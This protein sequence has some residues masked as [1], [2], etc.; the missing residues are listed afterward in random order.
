MRTALAALCCL[1]LSGIAAAV[2][3]SDQVTSQAN[4]CYGEVGEHKL[5]LDVFLPSDEATSGS[6]KRLGVLLIHGGGWVG[7]NK[8]AYWTDAKWF[9]QHGIVAFCVGY[10][11]VKPDTNRWPTQLDDIQLAVR[12]VRAHAAEYN[13]DPDQV[14]ATGGSAGGH[15]VS[16]LGTR[17]TRKGTTAPLQQYSSK[18]QAVVDVF[19]PADLTK[20][21]P[22]TGPYNLNVQKMVDDLLAAPALS[23]PELAREASPVFFASK[24]SAPFLIFHGDKDALVPVQQSIEFDAA[25]KKAGA[26]STLVIMQGEG[27]GLR[28]ENLKRWREES[29]AFFEKHLRK[30]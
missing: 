9:A 16:L 26:E 14:G 2:T 24:S 30:Q 1:I 17:D 27:H 25:L 6:A 18:V 19:G 12:W 22:T 29:L 13:I 28:P 15:L 5:L 10:R 4:V 11:L 7:G 23:N 8:S 20:E 3:A 21:F